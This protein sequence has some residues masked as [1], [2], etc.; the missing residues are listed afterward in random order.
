MNAQPKIRAPRRAIKPPAEPAGKSRT[1][2]CLPE[3]MLGSIHAVMDAEGV[4][5]K[6][7]SQWI[8]TTVERLFGVT[9]YEELIL[10]EFI[11]PGRNKTIPVSLSAPLRARIDK[12]VQNLTREADRPV[13][14]SALLRTAISQ[15][16]LRQRRRA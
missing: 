1:T 4:S 3:A 7:R 9:G 8:E 6:R 2:L 12:T 5:R 11:D 13:E 14:S 16:L 10:E 15:Y